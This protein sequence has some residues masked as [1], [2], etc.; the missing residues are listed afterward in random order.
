MLGRDAP[1]GTSR[2]LPQRVSDSFPVPVDESALALVVALMAL[3]LAWLLSQRQVKTQRTSSPV[4][5]EAGW[6]LMQVE[7]SAT[8]PI[9]ALALLY[10][11]DIRQ[12]R[13]AHDHLQ[14][15]GYIVA[16]LLPLQGRR[17]ES[18]LTPEGRVVLDAL[19]Q[20]RGGVEELL[21]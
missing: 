21:R 17:A 5:A 12:L 13:A 18:A 20:R 10:R 1:A 8:P 11:R 19:V 6:L 14:Q 9:D 7:R 3:L 2:A 15:R 4:C 16:F